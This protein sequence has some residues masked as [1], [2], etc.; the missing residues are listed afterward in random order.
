MR[1]AEE[2]GRIAKPE[3]K[4]LYQ[5]PRGLDGGC[6]RFLALGL[7]IAACPPAPLNRAK[8]AGRE[9]DHFFELS[10]LGI[11]HPQSERLANPRARLLQR[12]AVGVTA[13]D[14][15]HGDD[16]GAAVVS[17]EDDAIGLVTHR[18]SYLKCLVT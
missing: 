8:R 10:S 15:G 1:E 9:P 5:R 17:L 4:V 11:V 12:P 14:T 18:Y 16:P 7:G 13:A 6:G 2:I 3:L